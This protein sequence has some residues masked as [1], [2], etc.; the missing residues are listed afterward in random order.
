[1]L[2]IRQKAHGEVPQRSQADNTP[3]LSAREKSIL[4]CMVDGD[5]NKVIAR[6]IDI[7]EATVKVHVKAILRKIRVHNRTQGAIWAMNNGASLWPENHCSPA[8]ADASPPSALVPDRAT[9]QVQLASP[10]PPGNRASVASVTDISIARKD[11]KPRDRSV[12]R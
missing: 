10:E 11:C 1:M 7:T 6:K 8:I 3:R 9:E 4:R 12:G 5:S 2:P